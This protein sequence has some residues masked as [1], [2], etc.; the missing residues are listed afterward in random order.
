M[1]RRS[2]MPLAQFQSSA[3]PLVRATGPAT[4]R[5]RLERSATPLARLRQ[6]A[7]AIL[8]VLGLCAWA[9]SAQIGDGAKARSQQMSE[10]E[11][12]LRGLGGKGSSANS[13]QVQALVAQVEDDFKQI[14]VLHNQIATATEAGK[15]LDYRFVSEAAAETKKRA[16]RLQAAL[17]LADA[18]G[19][20]KRQDKRVEF[21][22]GQ[23]R[24]ALMAL[25]GRIQ[26]FV[27]NPVIENP[28]T[29]DSIES[30]R[31]RRDLDSVIDLSGRIRKSAER[32]RR[33][34]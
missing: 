5:A 21:T 32:L 18:Q 27:K 17:A 8:M 31:A 14:L 25:C 2:A 3:F 20:D 4:P 12:Q 13:K 33:K 23:V 16:A 26:S 19:S 9:A 11:T 28:G 10:R 1:K 24:E 6:P 15:T 30:A 22:D 34:D 7:F 29:V